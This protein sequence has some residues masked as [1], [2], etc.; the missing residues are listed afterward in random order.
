MDE[1]TSRFRLV[2][3]EPVMGTVVTFDV[4]DREFDQNALDDVFA[5]LRW[6][7]RTFSTYQSDSEVSRLSRDEI[8]LARCSP[9]LR[10]VLC[11]GEEIDSR[12]GGA[13]Q[14]VRGG[15]LDPSA[16]V[17]GWSI[18]RAA[19]ILER[20][21]ARNF[22]INAGGDVLA[23]GEAQPGRAW[24]V[25]IQH[26]QRR[27]RLA[28]VFEVRDRAVATSG[29]YERG[30]HIVDPRSGRPVSG[31]L[32]MTV[33]GPS[34][35]YADAYSTAACVM[36]RDGATWIARLDGYDAYVV[37]AEGRTVW[38]EGIQPLPPAGSAERTPVVPA[39]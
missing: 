16:L 39:G 30:N 33:I 11:L 26:P 35:G 34:L 32:S 14:V 29:N 1:L 8:D 22:F 37:T 36:G 10:E 19:T 2:R 9:E 20:S 15:R 18:D 13:F 17:K 28:A 6:V 5:W 7:D 4:R 21:G 25:G 27:D 23:R 12:S 3:A 38:T 31:L 24:R